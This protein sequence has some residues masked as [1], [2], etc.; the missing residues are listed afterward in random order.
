MCLREQKIKKKETNFQSSSI[1][2]NPISDTSL[3]VCL[4]AQKMDSIINEK[5]S[6]D[7]PRKAGK[8][9]ELILRRSLK[10]LIRWSGKSSKLFVIICN[11]HSKT[12]SKTGGILKKYKNEIKDREQSEEEGRKKGGKTRNY[13]GGN[14]AS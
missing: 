8:H 2:N 4:K 11:V 1:I 12:L 14:E 10:N 13:L 7:I 9:C 3:I 6:S 5:D